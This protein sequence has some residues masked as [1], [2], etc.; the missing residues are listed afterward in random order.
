MDARGPSAT[1][2]GIW[3]GDPTQQDTADETKGYGPIGITKAGREDADKDTLTEIMSID[4]GQVVPFDTMRKMKG[5]LTNV[6][7]EAKN[8]GELSR[9]ALEKGQGRMMNQNEALVEKNMSRSHKPVKKRTDH[10]WPSRKGRA[11]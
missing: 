5:K 1:L 6:E 9:M 4:R 8:L 7:R 3:K 2:S 10:R 11:G